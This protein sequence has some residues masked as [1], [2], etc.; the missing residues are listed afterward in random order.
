MERHC[1]DGKLKSTLHAAAQRQQRVL[2]SDSLLKR[3][4][5]ISVAPYKD[6]LGMENQ[7]ECDC[8]KEQVELLTQLKGDEFH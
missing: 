3:P 1:A 4:L 8:A 2:R 7:K 6:L 5:G